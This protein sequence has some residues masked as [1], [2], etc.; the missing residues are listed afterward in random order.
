MLRTPETASTPWRHGPFKAQL[1]QLSFGQ[2]CEDSGIELQAFKPR[3]RVFCIA[4]AGC[5]ARALAA[6]GH[7]VTAVDINPLQLGYAQSRA[8]GGPLRM[9]I[10]E[11]LLVFGRNLAKLAGWS[12]GKLTDFLNLSD[13]DEQVEYWDRR[14]DT[15]AWRAAVDTLLAPRLLGIC[16]A[17]PFIES[18]PRD[19]GLRLRQRLRR[20][21]STHSNRSNPYAA[22]LLLGRPPVEPNAPESL[23]Q[24]VCADAADF[25][26]CCP[27][28]AF[29][30]FSLS[31]IGDGVSPEYLCRLR[32]AIDHAAAPNAIVVARTFAE[33]GPNT[34]ANRA[35]LDRS[36]LWGVVEVSRTAE[37]CPGGKSCYTC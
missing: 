34:L 24:F 1:R 13:P 27:P 26:E 30:G 29:D 12:P 32:V 5:T 25:L 21:W 4:G 10:A 35:P 33:P 9:G 37:I 7:H 22:S 3:S 17:S 36:L 14:L 15:Q 23:I 28:A 2:T 8:A 19:F 20:T 18:L 16:Y 6:A 31:N 11:R